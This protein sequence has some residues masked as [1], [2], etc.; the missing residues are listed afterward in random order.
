LDADHPENG[1]LI[2][3]RFTIAEKAAGLE[4]AQQL[5]GKRRLEPGGAAELRD[6]QEAVALDEIKA[7]ESIFRE[8]QAR[9]GQL[10]RTGRVFGVL[11]PVGISGLHHLP[12][13]LVDCRSSVPS[14]SLVL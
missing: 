8:S 5:G 12:S 10:A 9:G 13:S 6:G 4:A 2:P 11:R 14:C 3:R 1:V 7:N